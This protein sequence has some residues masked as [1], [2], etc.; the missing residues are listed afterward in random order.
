V[1]QE[2]RGA[3]FVKDDGKRSASGDIDDAIKGLGRS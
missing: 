1:Q 3:K 2:V